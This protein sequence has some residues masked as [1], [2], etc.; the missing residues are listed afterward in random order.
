MNKYYDPEDMILDGMIIRAMDCPVLISD[1]CNTILSKEES[2]HL[3]ALTHRAIAK[4]ALHSQ[5]SRIIKRTM[6]FAACLLL[7][8]TVSF[9]VIMNVDAWKNKIIQSSFEI[10]D[11]HGIF[12]VNLAK[13][14][15]SQYAPTYIPERFIVYEEIYSDEDLLVLSYTVGSERYQGF[16]YELYHTKTQIAV[17]RKNAET[18]TVMCNDTQCELFFYPQLGDR[19]LIGILPECNKQFQIIGDLTEEEIIAIANS[20]E[21]QP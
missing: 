11:D 2:D 14:P 4:E 15:T 3:D 13:D 21:F 20:I 7:L 8:L 19:Q 18:K 9:S 5:Q 1:S 10:F 6:K 17:D 16:T 12:S